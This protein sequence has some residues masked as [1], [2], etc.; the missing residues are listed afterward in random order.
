MGAGCVAALLLL[1]L[2]VAA[3][4]WAPVP[5]AMHHTAVIPAR[6][7]QLQSIFTPAYNTTQRYAAAD[8]AQNLRTLPRSVTL[9]RISS[10]LLAN[11]LITFIICTLHATLGALPILAPLPH[12]LLGS[13]LGLLLVFRTN[14]AYDR[15][16]EARKTWGTVTNEC[17]VFAGCACT[18]MT[19]RQALPILSL[20][21]AF[22]VVMKT[23]LRGKRDT[24]RL[25]A[26]LAP[27]EIEALTAVVNQPQYVLARLRQLAQQ[28]KVCDVSEKER[29]ILFK[30]IAALGECVS[31]CER[32]YN[33]PIPLAYSRHTSRFLVL[34]LSTLPLTLVSK[35]GWA[36]LP[37]M[38]VMCWALFGILEIGNLIEEPFTAV[39]DVDRRPLLPLTEVCRTIRRDVRSVAQYASLAKECSA[40]R[41]VL[42]SRSP[43]I[44]PYLN[45]SHRISP[46]L[47]VSHHVSPCPIVSHRVSPYLPTFDHASPPLWPSLTSHADPGPCCASAPT[48]GPKSATGQSARVARGLREAT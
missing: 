33:T 10:P 21:A 15:F 29:E 24:R 28:S 18:F 47:T 37:V 2:T 7:R 31:T 3:S 26:L 32:I 4:Y 36:T 1:R 11:A 27:Q 25:K 40:P 16:W 42:L 44:S 9:K 19:P 41:W 12:T 20:I 17:R 13:A 23:Y 46:H 5:P 43:H 48:Q 34:W 22:P 14:A 8:W 39:T 38:I 35:L 6:S 30:S 45:I